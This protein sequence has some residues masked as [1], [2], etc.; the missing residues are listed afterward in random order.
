[1]PKSA[2]KGS[3]STST[4]GGN[5]LRQKDDDC[6]EQYAEV[7][8]AL[9]NSQFSIKF[10]NGEESKAKL[11]GSMSKRRTFTKV[12]IGDLVLVQ[13]DECTTGRD[14]FYIIHRYS[15]DEKRMLERM[16]E[17]VVVNEV[18]NDCSFMFEGDVEKHGQ[19][20]VKLSSDFFDGI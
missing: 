4:N 16:K 19:T 1:M 14:S 12:S 8:K 5:I 9:G 15:N 18:D 3:K 7:L 2:K 6:G 10:L 11:K 17:L 13:R 20:T